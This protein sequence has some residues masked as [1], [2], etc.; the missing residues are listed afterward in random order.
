[1]KNQFKLQNTVLWICIPIILASC[2]IL[3]LHFKVHNPKKRSDFLK[4]EKEIELLAKNTNLRNSFDVVH[5]NLDLQIEPST[6]SISGIVGITSKAITNLDTLQL[7]LDQQYKIESIAFEKPSGEK[8]SYTR[9]KKSRTILIK[10]PKTINSGEYLSVFITYSGKPKEAKKAPW[11]GGVVWKTDKLKFPWA[12]VACEGEGASIWFP[13]KD[14]TRDEPDSVTSRFSTTDTSL[15]M[16]SN[17][18]FIN[19]ELSNNRKYYNWK[20]SY[21]INLYNITFYLGNFIE[22]KDSYIGITD[23]TLDISY[24]VLQEHE[25]IA[26][27]HLQQVKKHL[28]VYESLYAPYPWYNDGFKLVESPYAGMEHQ[29]AIA[30]GTKFKNDINGTDDY[31]I[32]HETGHEWFGNAITAAD[33][34][35]IWIQEGITTYGEYLYLERKYGEDVAYSHLLFQR[36]TIKNKRPLIGPAEKRYFNYH[37]GDV[38]VKGAWMLHTLRNQLNNDSQYLKIIRTFYHT[39]FLKV[40]NSDSFISAVN[41]V[42]GKNY[43][44][45]FNQYLYN[46]F[47]PFVEYYLDENS[48]LYYRWTYTNPEFTRMKIQFQYNTSEEFFE[49]MPSSQIKQFKLPLGT[50]KPEEVFFQNNKA[51]YGTKENKKLVALYKSQFKKKQ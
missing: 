43:Q 35:D 33:L 38:Y 4:S 44:W 45:F 16:V 2:S 13:C 10:L 8:L 39:N 23:K 47:V 36:M 31:I 6:K 30:Y 37:D 27:N 15:V 41:R 24:F 46:N 5:Y 19:S 25:N 42:T 11:A 40:T 49:L 32:V 26:K 34:K 1:M 48:V 18:K 21:P 17:G 20:V 50:K 7:D 12:G 51:L 9:N 14:D 28:R 3:G 29:T 22:I